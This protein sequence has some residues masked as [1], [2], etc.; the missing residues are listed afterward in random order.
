MKMNGYKYVGQYDK[1]PHVLMRYAIL[2]DIYGIKIPA[3]VE[4][5]HLSKEA[6]AKYSREKHT[7]VTDRLFFL[8][9]AGALDDNALQALALNKSTDIADVIAAENRIAADL[10]KNEQD[11]LPYAI[12]QD[13]LICAAKS[14]MYNEIQSVSFSEAEKIIGLNH[15]AVVD[16][17][18]KIRDKEYYEFLVGLGER[19][20]FI[21]EKGE[22]YEE[23]LAENLL[24]NEEA[25]NGNIGSREYPFV[26]QPIKLVYYAQVCDELYGKDFIRYAKENEIPLDDTYKAE[27]DRYVKKIK[28]HFEIRSYKRLRHIC[29]KRVN[30]F[31]YAV[32]IDGV[33]TDDL[34][35][36]NALKA[37]DL[38]VKE[39]YDEDELIKKALDSCHSTYNFVDDTVIEIYH[40]S[41]EMLFVVKKTEYIP[42]DK[43]E[44]HNL[45]FD[46]NKIWSIIQMCSR[47]GQLKKMDDRIV[48]PEDI[49]NEIAPNEREYADR[50]I[51]E[52]YQ[53]QVEHRKTNKLLQSLSD[54]KAAAAEAEQEKAK[55]AAAKANQIQAHTSSVKNRGKPTEG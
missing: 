33:I 19:F 44:F 8:Y 11:R 6:A 14:K 40:G 38:D 20:G 4:I 22:M 34:K 18:V 30:W 7:P 3:D 36:K 28:L 2:A 42:V 45:L 48:I 16:G 35:E 15:I 10:Q 9:G 54:L 29:G 1:I 26:M 37:I 47:N 32:S 21:D 13:I 53:R 50:L 17:F 25:A 23:K 39:D 31:D 55:A 43:D 12:I 27:Y 24:N 52:Q 41:R 49:W 5:K 46:F 51:R